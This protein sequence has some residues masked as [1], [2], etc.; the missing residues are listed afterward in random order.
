MAIIDELETQYAEASELWR[1]YDIKLQEFRSAVKN[2]VASLEA[3]GRKAFEAVNKIRTAHE[4]TF[5]VLN[6][7][8]MVTAIQNAERLA[9]A[10][11]QIAELRS[12]KLTLAV[13]D[14]APG[15]PE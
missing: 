9:A 6:S 10:L 4:K 3:S 13:I 7:A 11:R 1:R 15:R 8:D 5:E 12:H 2:D 14:A